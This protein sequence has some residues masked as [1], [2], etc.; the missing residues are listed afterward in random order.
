MR[1]MVA[2]SILLTG[3]HALSRDAGLSADAIY[4]GSVKECNDALPPVLP[5]LA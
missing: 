3:F 1:D 4:G 5:L 2:M